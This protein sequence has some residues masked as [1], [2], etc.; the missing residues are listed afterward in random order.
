ML[1]N[2]NMNDKNFL[3][4]NQYGCMTVKKD[5]NLKQML[6]IQVLQ[7]IA[8]LSLA[9]RDIAAVAPIALLDMLLAIPNL[10]LL[11]HL[12]L[13]LMQDSAKQRNKVA[14][15]IIIVLMSTLLINSI[16]IIWVECSPHTAL[17]AAIWKHLS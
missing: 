10:L 4:L 17:N 15:F 16:Q 14:K 1:F 6:A 5:V 13:V 7:A 3:D 11:C 8:V 12:C 9:A 2:K